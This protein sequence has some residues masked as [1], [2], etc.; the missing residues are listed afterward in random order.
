VRRHFTYANVMATIAVLLGLTGTAV[1]A[2]TIT[3]SHVVDESLTTR[4]VKNRTLTGNDINAGTLESLNEPLAG[5]AWRDVM[6]SNIFPSCSA[7]CAGSRDWTLGPGTDNFS[8]FYE[9]TKSEPTYGVHLD[10]ADYAV[11]G[12]T[13]QVRLVASVANG[14]FANWTNPVQISLRSA[15]LVTAPADWPSLES[16]ETPVATASIPAESLAIGA[17]P[18]TATT[19]VTLNEA[20]WYVPVISSNPTGPYRTVFSVRVQV[21]NIEG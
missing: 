13:T 18:K 5:R 9:G 4:D 3:G 10:P 14:G 19:P 15:D 20:G 7:D 17:D 2:A 1:A 11:P 12:T 8:S 6:I 16:S 21:R